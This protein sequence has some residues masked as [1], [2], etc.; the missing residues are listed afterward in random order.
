[1]GRHGNVICILRPTPQQRKYVHRRSYGHELSLIT[2]SISGPH[3]VFSSTSFCRGLRLPVQNERH[4]R[5]RV[6]RDVCAS[7]LQCA[8][9]LCTRSHC[10]FRVR[11]RLP[12]Q[13]LGCKRRRR[14]GGAVRSD[15]SSCCCSRHAHAQLLTHA[16]RP[17]THRL[18]NAALCAWVSA[19]GVA[20]GKWQKQN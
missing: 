12:L 17:W 13:H 19:A 14:V 6:G 10:R 4:L 3:N 20:S 8:R 16:L 7:V 5:L 11:R 9:V 2:N 15:R 18:W 1:M